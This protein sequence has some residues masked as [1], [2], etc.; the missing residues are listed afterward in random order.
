MDNCEASQ[1]EGYLFWI[2]VQS[3]PNEVWTASVRFERTADQTAVTDRVQGV[4]HLIKAS[5]NGVYEAKMAA[6]AYAIQT[7]RSDGVGL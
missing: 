6:K 3:R 2:D 7:I 4:R 5:L 1:H